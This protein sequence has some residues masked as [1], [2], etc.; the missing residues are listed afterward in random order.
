MVSLLRAESGE[1]QQ[2]SLLCKAF[3]PFLSFLYCSFRRVSTCWST[4]HSSLGD[5][6]FF[7]GSRNTHSTVP[8]RHAF[9]SKIEKKI[10][11]E[12]SKYYSYSN[13]APPPTIFSTTK[14]KKKRDMSKLF[15]Y[16]IC[17]STTGLIF[18]SS[19]LSGFHFTNLPTHI[20]H[21]HGNIVDN[22]NLY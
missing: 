16:C 12:S 9:A 18:R 20:Y 21:V 6:S 8:F 22:G 4:P 19:V 2:T 14:K 5:R 13:P 17:L 11:L 7:S 10:P 15:V 3:L 1:G